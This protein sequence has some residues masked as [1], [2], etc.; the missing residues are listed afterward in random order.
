MK[1]A[2]SIMCSAPW[3]VKTYVKKFE[4]TKIPMI[5]YDVMD[6]NYVPNISIGSI[7]FRY[8]NVEP[9]CY[10]HHSVNYLP[11]Y[12][13]YVCMNYS[14]NGISLGSYLPPN[15]D[16]I[17]VRFDMK[18]MNNL[19][20]SFA[21]Q[22]IR[23]GADFGNQSVRGSSIYSE[24]NNQDRDELKKYFLHDGAYNWIHAISA[25]GSYV[26]KQTRIPFKVDLTLG[27]VISYF[28]AIDQSNYDNKDAYGN[29]DANFDT[30][31]SVIDTADYP[32]NFGPVFT[33]GFTV[34]K[35]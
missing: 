9:Y 6:G 32:F 1:I 3:D 24:L 27:F 19:S 26:S 7:A 4:E 17:L 35:F 18:P 2:P 22:L 30:P 29:S 23:H 21:Y 33:I 20:T 8:T 31:Y 34:G 13:G 14:N 28:T 15:S 11:Y 5:H 16:E 10:T 12:D 25:N